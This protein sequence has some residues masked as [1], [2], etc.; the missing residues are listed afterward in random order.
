MGLPVKE[1][2]EYYRNEILAPFFKSH[3]KGSGDFELPEAMV[4]ESGKNEWR[5]YDSWPPRQAG[6][7]SFFLS[8]NGKLLETPPDDSV[9]EYTRFVSDPAVPVPHL[10]ARGI[11]GWNAAVMH[12]DQRFAASRED[13]LVFQGEIL[14]NDMTLAGPIE[15]ELHVSTT[16][17]DADWVVK[18]IDVLPDD[19]GDL[20]GYQMLVPHV[21]PQ[22]TDL[23][24]HLQ[25]DGNRFPE[26]DTHR[27]PLT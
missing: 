10:P 15:V 21:R 13:V 23:R 16:G 20:S 22:S 24:R 18:V 27:L 14:Q 2:G 4:I 8:G 17:T 26:D 9:E 3:L 7:K 6:P 1:T 25:G 5:E 11:G 19:A 12:F